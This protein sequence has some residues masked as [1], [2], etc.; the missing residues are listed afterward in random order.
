MVSGR[1]FWI[2]WG[3][4][5]SVWV[6]ALLVSSPWD[7]EI[8]AAVADPDAA[9]GR[10]VTLAGEWPAWAAVLACIYVLIAGRGR[11]SPLHPLWIP[12]LGIVLLAVLHPLAIT[13]GFK[14]LWGRV[15]FRD[16]G[17]GLAGYT[18]F[19]LPAGP[20]AGLSFPSGHVAMAFVVSPVVF[21]LARLR[22]TLPA[23]IALAVV[24][25][26]GCL[27]AFGRIQAGAHYFTDCLFSAGLSFLLAAA[28]V[29]RLAGDA[30]NRPG[31]GVRAGP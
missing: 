1:T 18:P 22:G 19:Y 20:G 10:L 9:F 29:R 14:F 31:R 11:E 8:S 4:C 27:V 24:L 17:A 21:F 6:A 30:R 25:P 26:Y 2:A 15:R 12:A 5:F 13:Q 3:T 7:L 16:L 23:L 28:V